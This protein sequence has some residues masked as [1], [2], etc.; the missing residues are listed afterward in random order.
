MMLTMIENRFSLHPSLSLARIASLLPFTY[1]GA[2]LY[3]LCSDAMLKAITRQA[4][5]VDAKVKQLN[6][7]RTASN[8]ADSSQKAQ[9]P[10]ITTAHFFDHLATEVDTA[11]M[12]T[13]EDFLSA[14]AELVPSV[15][16]DELRHYE[17]V[18]RTFEGQAKEKEK[19]KAGAASGQMTIGDAAAAAAAAG[20]DG[21][22]GVGGGG[23]GKG[24]GKGKAGG[25]RGKGKG[26]AMA[27]GDDV[28]DEEGEDDDGNQADGVAEVD[29]DEDEYVIR[30]DHL[31]T[32]NGSAGKG[33]GKAATAEVEGGD[34][35]AVAFGEGAEG[36]EDM[37]Q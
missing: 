12:V 29:D 10:P 22:N 33:K 11:V 17:R 4:N 26:K 20:Q 35:N 8:A 16:V 27:S 15:S 36:D 30:T 34:G 21:I 23:G 3:A 37:Y 6:A 32:A 13:E 1:T 31:M 9:L 14:K 19:E 24:K 7:E 5:A 28:G 25:A 2:D 18:R